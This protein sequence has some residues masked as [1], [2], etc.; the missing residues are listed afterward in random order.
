M[1]ITGTDGDDREKPPAETDTWL[2]LSIPGISYAPL[3]QGTVQN[4]SHPPFLKSHATNQLVH[5]QVS[6]GCR[7]T[8]AYSS[9]CLEDRVILEIL[10]KTL[11][12]MG[13]LSQI[14]SKTKSFCASHNDFSRNSL[15]WRNALVMRMLSGGGDQP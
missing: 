5:G 3:S 9:Q 13:Y 15:A 10:G 14:S 6:W 1:V 12:G 2:G 11:Q 8:P 4:S 7:V